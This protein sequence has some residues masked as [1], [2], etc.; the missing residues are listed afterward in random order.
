[1]GMQTDAG[2]TILDHVSSPKES[3][4][5]VGLGEIMQPTANYGKISEK[6]VQVD[7]I[8]HKAVIDVNTKGIEAAAATS[9]SIVPKFGSFKAEKEVKLDRPFLY[10]IVENSKKIIHFAGVLRNPTLSSTK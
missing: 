8:N 1:M 9:I 5:T 3:L 2:L 7:A 4:E 10:F 6:P